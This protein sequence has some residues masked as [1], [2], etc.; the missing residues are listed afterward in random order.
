MVR[1]MT[2][3][4]AD[5]IGVEVAYATPHKQLIIALQVTV[6]TTALE[7]VHRSN[8]KVEFPE[9]DID[10]I[11]MGIFSKPLDG[12]SRPLPKDYKLQIRDRV[13]LYRPLIIDPKEARLARAAKAKM[14]N[15]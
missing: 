15:N 1:E 5:T 13:E 3:E 12:K 10:T 6:G 9:I 14:K 7:A 8:I 11:P 4:R 2:E